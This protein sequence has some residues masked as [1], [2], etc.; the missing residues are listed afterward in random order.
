MYHFPIFLVNIL[1]KGF[2]PTLEGVKDELCFLSDLKF[3]KLNRVSLFPASAG[4]VI[5]APYYCR[6]CSVDLQFAV[7]VP[8]PY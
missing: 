7:V 4:A 2:K 5:A 8:F 3:E 1:I 6:P